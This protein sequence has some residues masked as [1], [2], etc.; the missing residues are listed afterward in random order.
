MDHKSNDEFWS[1][2]P[3]KKGVSI[4]QAYDSCVMDFSSR[5]FASISRLWWKIVFEKYSEVKIY[6]EYAVKILRKLVLASLVH[7]VDS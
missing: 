2:R 4:Y 3:A 6:E 1:G 7:N 5:I